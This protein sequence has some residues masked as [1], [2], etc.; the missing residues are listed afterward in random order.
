MSTYW[1]KATCGLASTSGN[2]CLA[3]EK[4][5]YPL[6]LGAD[7]KDQADLRTAQLGR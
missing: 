6:E 7:A 3:E 1:I 2:G 4:G 5:D